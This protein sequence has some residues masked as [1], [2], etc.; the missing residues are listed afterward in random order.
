[1][2]NVF[3]SVLNMSITSSYFVLALIVI[4]AVFRK[5]PKWLSCVL[6]G[7]VGLRLIFPFSF[8]SILSL[9]PST[10]TVPSDIMYQ[11]K[12]H[13]T[14]GIPSLNSSLNPIIN[15]AFA[16]KEFTSANPL[17][18]V[19]FIASVLWITGIGIML[20]YTFISF[21]LLKRK[22]R[23]S[24]K[25][26]KGIFICDRIDTPFIL[27]LINPRIYLP[28][29]IAED[30]CDFIIS[31]EKA[32]IRRGDHLWKP[33]GFLLLSVYWFNPFM[34]AAYIFLC[35]DIEGACDERV[36]REQGEDIKKAYSNAL[37]NCSAPKRL[38]RACPLAFGETGVK[39]RI[40]S[41][42][43]YKKPTLWIII[44]AALTA[45]ILALCFMSDP[46]STR[47]NDIE[48]N[49]DIFRDVNKLQLY[50]GSGYIYTTEDPSEELKLI[51][52]VKLEDTP[53]NE[54]RDEGRDKSFRVELDDKISINI[55]QSF[56]ALWIDDGVKPTFSYT[57]KNPEILKNLFSISFYIDGEKTENRDGVY[58]TLDRI[59]LSK[60]STD[61]SVTW[62]NETDNEIG[63][64]EPFSI[65]RFENNQWIK[66]PFPENYV[67]L[68]PEY[69]LKAHTCV[70]KTYYFPAA[71]TE[72]GSYR[73]STSYNGS[74][75]TTYFVRAFFSVGASNADIGG[76]SGPTAVLTEKK[77]TLDDI[78][79]LSEKGNDLSWADFDDYSYTETG[80]GIYV[81]QYD[82]DKMFYLTVGAAQ[83]NEE[84][85]YI[86]LN[87]NDATEDSSVDIRTADVKAFINEHK[88]NLI[89]KMI[90]YSYSGFEIEYNNDIFRCMTDLGGIPS[91]IA[92]SSFQALPLVRIGSVEQLS[93]FI[94][95][96]SEVTKPVH[97]NEHS[98]YF[99][100]YNK[101]FFKSST[102]IIIYSS[103]LSPVTAF[104][105]QQA[106]LSE[107]E[108]TLTITIDDVITKTENPTNDRMAYLTLFEVEN[109]YLSYVKEINAIM[110]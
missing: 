8:E 30:D 103:A 71:L 40:K 7:L 52:K 104:R 82:I 109:D 96:I 25:T 73:L 22:T 61:F 67:F 39:S 63:Y 72:N 83:Y 86:R 99:E 89:L 100:N 90:S 94:R 75:D 79:R 19:L 10:Q 5:I 4:R 45:I 84:P 36:L 58:I 48:G 68:L 15:E 101:E 31:H 50:I 28:S 59:N 41:I 17:Q 106:V 69:M 20:I 62:H 110:Y 2:E 66:V 37:V 14:S 55:D 21:I 95:E 102:L 53:I 23:E 47:I 34:W 29:D 93:V 65:E 92:Y 16:P 49:N 97:F 76:A 26:D 56:S 32:H 46:I 105:P 33:L 88:N 6:W 70:T 42:L 81:R 35:R 24:I 54:S 27:G 108:D 87:A 44:T 51:K 57:I 38:I 107:N 12:P 77:L 9:I 43:S 18:I 80:F 91:L 74:D 13:I 64:G 60:D 78:L 85:I 1:M 3:I 11:A 98:Y